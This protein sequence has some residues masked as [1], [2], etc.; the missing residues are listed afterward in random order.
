MTRPR[1]A[2]LAI[3]T[4]DDAWAELAYDPDTDTDA[5]YRVRTVGW[6]VRDTPRAIVLAAE[7][8]PDG[9]WRGITRVPRPIVLRVEILRDR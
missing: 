8:L 1:P 9:T 3:V 4:W 6:I 2:P 7:R 5:P